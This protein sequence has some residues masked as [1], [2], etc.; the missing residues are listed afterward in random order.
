MSL[1]GHVYVLGDDINTDYIIAAKYRALS[2]SDMAARV[3]EDIDPDFTKK[4]KTGD[5]IIGGDNFGCG[6]SREYAPRVILAAGI[7]G[8]AAKSF[9]RIFYRNSINSGLP[10]IECDTARFQTGD[11]ITVALEKGEIINHSQ[12][13]TASFAKLP[14]FMTRVLSEGGMS[15]YIK[16]HGG[17]RAENLV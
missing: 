7:Q 11:H 6:S 3:M 1:E 14:P 8:I 12:K 9:A 2:L 15:G 5:W 13:F 10:V 4:I 16:K 17:L